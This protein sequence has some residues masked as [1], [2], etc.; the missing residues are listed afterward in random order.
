[1]G[2]FNVLAAGPVTP[3]ASTAFFIREE[4]LVSIISLVTSESLALGD[5]S[6][7]DSSTGTMGKAEER[8]IGGTIGTD[9]DSIGNS[10]LEVLLSMPISGCSG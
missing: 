7:S 6:V 1:M 3:L 10:S 5:F 4:E 8:S 2:F 9:E